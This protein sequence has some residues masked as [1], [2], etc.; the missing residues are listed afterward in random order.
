M[1]IGPPCAAAV[2]FN[3]RLSGARGKALHMHLNNAGQV[4]RKAKER[5][6]QLSCNREGQES[7]PMLR[8]TWPGMGCIG[9]IAVEMAMVYRMPGRS[10]KSVSVNRKRLM[11]SQRIGCLMG[12]QASA[13]NGSVSTLLCCQ[14]HGG[15]SAKNG[16]AAD[17]VGQW[18]IS[19]P[20]LSS[21]LMN[22]LLLPLTPLPGMATKPAPPMMAQTGSGEPLKC[23][24]FPGQSPCHGA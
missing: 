13:G 7:R 11:D 1:A 5:S 23:G 18:H 19:L 16:P 4:S 9:Q 21:L 3:F 6:G 24:S 12:P 2:W 20:S 14:A 8:L 15:P 10:L 22:A 17:T